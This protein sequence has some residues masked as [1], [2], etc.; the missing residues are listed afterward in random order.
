MEL[1]LKQTRQFSPQYEVFKED[2]QI[3]R[4]TY[5]YIA[6]PPYVVTLVE[7]EEDKE[8]LTFSDHDEVMAYLYKTY[9]NREYV[10]Q[11]NA[12]LIRRTA[13]LRGASIPVWL[14]TA[15][16]AYLLRNDCDYTGKAIAELL[17]EFSTNLDSAQIKRLEGDLSAGI[18]YPDEILRLMGVL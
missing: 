12:E 10:P 16:I 4:I 1:T 5:R 14:R 18:M 15:G 7:D 13:Y 6:K 9:L 8:E 2:K 3:A 17:A 11:G